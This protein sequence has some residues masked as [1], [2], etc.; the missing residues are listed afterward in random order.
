[1]KAILPAVAQL[2][3][4]PSEDLI[5]LSQTDL[6]DEDSRIDDPRWLN[7]QELRLFTM[8]AA[9]DKRITVGELRLLIEIAK[10]TAPKQ[11]P[12]TGGPQLPDTGGPPHLS[13][14]GGCPF[15]P[16][17]SEQPSLGPATLA[18]VRIGG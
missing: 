18:G 11:I 3:G 10:L 4:V 14:T 13:D 8:Y 15:V 7:A 12:D 2:A 9:E 6:S 1:V 16:P 5:T 17:T